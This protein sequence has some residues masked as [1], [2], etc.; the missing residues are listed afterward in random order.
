[1]R[2]HELSES[3]NEIA[4]LLEL[5]EEN[6]FRIRAYRKAARN[7]ESLTQDIEEVARKGELLSI[8]GVGKDLADKTEEFLASGRMKA[9]D[10]LRKKI[11]SVLVDMVRIPGMGPKTARLIYEKLGVK[12][13]AD[14]KKRAEAHQVSKLPGIRVKTEENIL[15]GIRLLEQHAER[16][17][18][19]IALPLAREIVSKLRSLKEIDKV[20]IGGSV[21]RRCSMIR[22]IDILVTSRK[23][24]KVMDFFVKLPF[25]GEV[26][27]HG[28]TKSSVL[29]TSGIQLDVRV[30]EPESFGAALCYFTGSKEHNIRLRDLAKKRG[31]K[32]NEYGVFREKTNRKIAARDE[33]AVY[34]AVRLKWVPPELREDRGEIEAAQAGRLPHL[35]ELSDIRGDLHIHTSWSDGAKSIKE[36][37]EAA[38]KRGYDYIAITDHSRS[39]KIA[40]GL[41]ERDLAK[42]INEVRKLDS[43]MRPFRLLAGSE[44]DILQDGSLD[45]P[46]SLLRELDFVI[47][48]IHSGFKQPSEKLTG[49]IC[50]AME[51]GLVHMI[52]HP[53]GRLSGQRDSYAVDL[54]KVI[55]TA[56]D[57]GTSL[58]INA[59][60]DRLDLDDI[61]SRRAHEHGVSLGVNTDSHMIAQLDYMEYGVNVARRAWC[62]KKHILNTL[63]AGKLLSSLKR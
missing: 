58:E 29:T 19:G 53:T 59:Y 55:K 61:V 36:M 35:L 4:D 13:L 30:L 5:G 52:A 1:M 14:L 18:L 10:D 32:I 8:D 16:I 27:A 41:S 60:P 9:L 33:E 62:E 42:Q 44:V 22:D 57:T 21:R 31:L 39:L 7:I 37:A 28:V 47:A 40:G 45:Y 34:A 3:F 6:P 23:P 38:R 46:A 63:S 12:N 24:E 11:P 25:V 49:R 2:N 50:K 48:S 51:S 20:E 15:A 43:E 26:Q 56:R 17:S 54:E